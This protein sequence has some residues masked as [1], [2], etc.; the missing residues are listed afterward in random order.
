ME[1]YGYY[2]L[3]WIIGI[4]YGLLTFRSNVEK[5][6]HVLDIKVVLFLSVKGKG[7]IIFKYREKEAKDNII[8][9]QHKLFI[10]KKD[11]LMNRHKHR[12]WSKRK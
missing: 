11:F 10:F 1:L 3:H 12:K 7:I 4:S 9:Y 8:I 5:L 2:I 6:R